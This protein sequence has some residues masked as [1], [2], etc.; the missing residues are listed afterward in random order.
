MKTSIAKTFK[1]NATTLTLV[2]ASLSAMAAPPQNA[3]PF[4]LEIGTATCDAA[5]AKLGRVDESKLGGTDVLLTAKNPSALYDGASAAS[6]R[7]SEGRVIAVQIE[8]SKGGMG[9]E[10][11][12]E[13][14]AG[15]SKKYKLVAGGPMP[16]LGNGYARFQSGN[17]VIE[18]DA[19]HLSFEFTL[20]YFEKSFYDSLVTSSKD[21]EKKA[22][23]KK[24]SSL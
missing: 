8:A 19:P 6:V 20:T 24:Q 16:Q 15:L 10:G 17:S 14:F 22:A 4:N 7:C 2:L 1:F 13:V 11:A 21:K 23:D 3:A 9:N 18:Q 5:R 12:R